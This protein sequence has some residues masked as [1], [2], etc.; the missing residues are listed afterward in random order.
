MVLG[1]VKRGGSGG[2]P[3]P[4]EEHTR[5]NVSQA[6]FGE[7]LGT[8]STSS[9]AARIVKG[10]EE[11]GEDDDEDKNCAARAKWVSER[12]RGKSSNCAHGSAR[13]A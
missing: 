1:G 12:G 13:G 10:E 11:K 8:P 6:A 9:E 3:K 5:R 2:F 4:V 7:R